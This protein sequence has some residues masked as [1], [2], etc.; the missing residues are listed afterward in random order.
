MHRCLLPTVSLARP[1]PGG[2]DD[3][4]PRLPRTRGD[5][6]ARRE[7]ERDEAGARSERIA[8]SSNRCVPPSFT[9]SAMAMNAHTHSTTSS[10]ASKRVP[11][12][13]PS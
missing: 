5:D 11:V 7:A 12:C 3:V 13:E 10:A 9:S 2:D 8:Q 4:A 6:E 1:V